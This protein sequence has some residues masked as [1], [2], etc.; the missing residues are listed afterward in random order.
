T[1]G[2]ADINP[3]EAFDTPSICT[4]NIQVSGPLNFGTVCKGTF[5]D[6][7]L[8]I[9][10]TGTGDLIVNS[11]TRVSGNSTI[12]L[13]PDP[14]APIFISADA[15]V[16]INVKCSPSSFGTST[17]TFRI[18]SNDPDSPQTDVTYT[19]DA[20]QPVNDTLIASG[21]NFGDVCRGDFKDLN[22]T[23]NNSG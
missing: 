23:V 21:G 20:P 13:E 8:E 7:Q 10:N 11:I 6:N 3:V 2:P 17:A 16:D 9:F 12:S 22:L 4:P 15:H 5:Q 1:L 19:C 14:N 18:A